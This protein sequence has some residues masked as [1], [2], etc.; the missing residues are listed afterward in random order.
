M[1]RELGYAMRA[2]ERALSFGD[3]EQPAHNLT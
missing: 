1:I 3:G 2:A